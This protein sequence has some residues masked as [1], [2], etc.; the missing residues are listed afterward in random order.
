MTPPKASNATKFARAG[1]DVEDL[2]IRFVN[3]RAWRLRNPAEERLGSSEALLEWLERNGVITRSELRAL[4]GMWR[5]RPADAAALYDEAIQ[6]REA[7]YTLLVACI[8][9]AR[10]PASA[11]RLFSEFMRRKRPSLQLA[12]NRGAL[13]WRMASV[14]AHPCDVLAPIALSAA[15]LMTGVRASKVRQCQDEDGCGWLFVDESRLQNR[16]WCSMGDC[17][18]RAK[19]RRHRERARQS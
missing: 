14:R 5:E 2:A 11:V 10:P 9:G 13:A 6:L 19:T 4:A 15:E 8:Q 3:T 1:L 7:I 12:W 17:G 18:N 16:R